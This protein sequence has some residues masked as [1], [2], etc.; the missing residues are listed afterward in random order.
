MD[1]LEQDPAA[2]GAAPA[3]A[4]SIVPADVMAAAA[5][6]Q[7]AAPI[8]PG[9]PVPADQAIAQPI[10]YNAEAAEA[11]DL[12]TL[13]FPA[14]PT[15]ESIYTD[16]V[17]ARIAVRLAPVMRKYG[18]SVQGGGPELML[19]MATVPL[20][21]PTYRAIKADSIA[22]RSMKPIDRSN[23]D[24]VDGTIVDPSKPIETPLAAFPGLNASAAP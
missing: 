19:F 8:D 21:A 5:I 17:R 6:D 1:P 3:A 20:I 18:W 14:Y 13:V 16:A 22:A 23:V 11:V 7:P 9:A 24:S 12:V 15:L 10:D 4:P 2:P